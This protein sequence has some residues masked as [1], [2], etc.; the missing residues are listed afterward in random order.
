MSFSMLWRNGA[1]R[2]P[3]S[4]SNW[5]RPANAGGTA[6]FEGLFV[7]NLENVQGDERDHIIISTT[8]GPDEKGKFHRN[9]GP[10]GR[11]GGGRRF[12]V[13]VTRARE[14]IHLVTSIPTTEYRVLPDL[15]SGQAPSG[16]WLLYAY[17][18]YAESLERKLTEEQ[19]RLAQAR[20]LPKPVVRIDGE[21]RVSRLSVNLA[22]ELANR[23]GL[24]SQ[25]PWG[26]PGFCVDIVVQH[27][28]RPEDVTI[29]V[30]CDMTRF[31]HAADSVEWEL[32]RTAALEVQ[33]WKFHRGWSTT[34]YADPGMS[35]L[36]WCHFATSVPAAGR[37]SIPE[38]AQD[39]LR[40]CGPRADAAFGLALL[41]FAPEDDHR[42]RR[43]GEFGGERLAMRLV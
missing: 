30:L 21:E 34:L 4:P 2:I 14:M 33:G 26:N 42:Q 19:A 9:F 23:H 35:C 10:L 32:F 41:R 6:S 24:S 17:L 28:R 38:I 20:V 25:V 3:S 16:R 13:L 31:P 7:K 43:Q 15:E 37:Q 27:P 22:H 40:R 8:F 5:K 18:N 12:N 11:T 36:A 1:R 39:C 29:G